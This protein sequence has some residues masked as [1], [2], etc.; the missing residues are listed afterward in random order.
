MTKQLIQSLRSREARPMRYRFGHGR[1]PR[2]YVVCRGGLTSCRRRRLWVGT[3][4]LSTS[5]PAGRGLT[6]CRRRACG[7]GC[8]CRIC[9]Y[10]DHFCAHRCAHSRR[11]GRDAS[12]ASCR[13]R[14]RHD[15]GP[16][17]SGETAGPFA[18]RARSSSGA[19][20]FW[21]LPQRSLRSTFTGDLLNARF[22]R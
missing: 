17:A 14:R 15:K 6:S 22:A 10:H 3:H 5:T 8:G 7:C 1:A 2:R 16:T 20:S 9:C 13:P 11:S 19:E 12:R 18:V 4:V 21:R